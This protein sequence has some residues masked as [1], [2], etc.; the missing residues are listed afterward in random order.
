MRLI[1]ADALNKET[2]KQLE[3]LHIRNWEGIGTCLNAIH[4]AP[5][6]DAEP[7]RRGRWL[8][9]RV[10]DEFSYKDCFRCSE[11]RLTLDY[12]SNYCPICGAKM[13]G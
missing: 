4:N 10:Y 1:D 5:T 8:H 11:C 7:V 12:E 13:D 6:I 3:S 9:R 2:R